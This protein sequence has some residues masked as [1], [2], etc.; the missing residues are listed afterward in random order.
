MKQVFFHISRLPF[1]YRLPSTWNFRFISV[2]PLFWMIHFNRSD[3]YSALNSEY[4]QITAYL[5][6]QN[7]YMIPILWNYS[8]SYQY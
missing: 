1:P 6:D 8:R 7:N 3:A 5:Q 4:I 2:A